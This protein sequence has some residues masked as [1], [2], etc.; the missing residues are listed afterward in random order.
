MENRRSMALDSTACEMCILQKRETAAHL[1][2]RCNFAKACWRSV[3]IAYPSTRSVLS[4]FL[5]IR[6]QLHLPFSMEIIILMS[7]SIWTSRNDWTFNNVAP[8]I[9]DVTRKFISEFRQVA[10][11][12]ARPLL[13]PQMLEWVAAL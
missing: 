3:G 7:W 11:H 6:R 1:F 13:Q 2:L 5:N 10:L 8:A 4:I 9:R 12:R